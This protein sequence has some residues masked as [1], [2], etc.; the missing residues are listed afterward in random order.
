[1]VSGPVITVVSRS[2]P[3]SSS[4]TSRSPVELLRRTCG[5]LHGVHER[6]HDGLVLGGAGGLGSCW[7]R[8]RLVRLWRQVTSS[9]PV[10]SLCLEATRSAGSSLTPRPEC[11]RPQVGPRTIGRV[12]V[13][14]H[15]RAVRH[16]VPGSLAPG[17]HRSI[18][19]QAGELLAEQRRFLVEKILL[20]RLLSGARPGPSH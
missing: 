16:D 17:R 4:V 12:L 8:L 9:L 2:R 6:R 20:S 15:V 18:P 11:L 3:L 5:Q 1:M 13:L 10:I 19:W 7:R 14:T